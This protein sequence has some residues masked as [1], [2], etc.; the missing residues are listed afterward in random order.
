MGRWLAAAFTASLMSRISFDM[1]LC[2]AEHFRPQ[3]LGA[4]RDHHDVFAAGIEIDAAD[5]ERWTRGGRRSSCGAR[6]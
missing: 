1:S 6:V 2:Q 4:A 3:R 5:F